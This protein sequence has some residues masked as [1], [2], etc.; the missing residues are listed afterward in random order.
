M[1]DPQQD[2]VYATNA[3]EVLGT[4]AEFEACLAAISYGYSDGAQGHSSR[5]A[6]HGVDGHRNRSAYEQAYIRGRASW[7]RYLDGLI[8]NMELEWHGEPVE[9]AS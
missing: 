9:E 5:P 8:D 7:L 4:H 2:P 3:A 6:R 1:V